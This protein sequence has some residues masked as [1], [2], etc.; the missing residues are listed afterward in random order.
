MKKFEEPIVEFL[1]IQ[2][3]EPVLTEDLGTE[4]G[5]ASLTNWWS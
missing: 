1:S 2:P 5:V 4:F 3:E